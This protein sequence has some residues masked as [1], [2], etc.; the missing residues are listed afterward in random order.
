MVRVDCKD[1]IS[2]LERTQRKA[3]IGGKLI[4]QVV[5]CVLHGEEEG[6]KLTT[7]M[8]V[9]DG[10][11]SVSHFSCMTKDVLESDVEIVIPNIEYVISALKKHTGI[12][13]LTQAS[14]EDKLRIKSPSKSTSL[15]A[16]VRALAFPHTQETVVGWCE[17]SKALHKKIGGSTGQY[18]LNDGSLKQPMGK[19]EVVWRDFTDAIASGNINGQKIS[20]FKLKV[21]EGVAYVE[22]GDDLKGKMVSVIGSC[23]TEDFEWSFEGGLENISLSQKVNIF[24]QDFREQGQGIALIIYDAFGMESIFQRGVI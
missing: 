24:I 13:S 17:K 22:V 18:T 10:K 3:N 1:L 19:I 4:E 20:R 23:D 11:T 14:F 7:T 9:R 8:I 2:L 5:S 21:E 6:L 16:D 15:S 12:V